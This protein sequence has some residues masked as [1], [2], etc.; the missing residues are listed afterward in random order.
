MTGTCMAIVV[1]LILLKVDG[2]PVLDYNGVA[3]KAIY[4]DMILFLAVVLCISTLL[5]SDET[6]ITVFLNN[7]LQPL[8]GLENGYIFV[9]VFLLIASLLTQVMN[10][11]VV[12]IIFL[13]IVL[14]A[15][16][17]YG[18]NAWALVT[19]LIGAA[20]FIAYGTPAA[21]PN[22]GM[23]YSCEYTPYSKSVKYVI[24][25]LCVWFL[26]LITIGYVL[27]KLAFF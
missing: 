4:W 16:S 1:I 14:V 23:M 12:E 2:K 22:A 5:T 21:C 17:S 6:G 15:S 18:L 11:T 8:L 20:Q 9:I 13:P 3:K 10:K 7:V 27:A 24:P 19:L 26:S 25:V